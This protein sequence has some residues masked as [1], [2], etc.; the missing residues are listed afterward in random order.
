MSML[1][2]KKMSNTLNKLMLLF[3]TVFVF[4]P[5]GYSQSNA[6][7]GIGILMS[8][9]SVTQGSSGILRATVGNYGND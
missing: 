9:S 8:P 7:P 1:N 6:D 2:N 5:K 4:I 3:L